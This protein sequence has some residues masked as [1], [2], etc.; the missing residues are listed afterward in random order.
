[1]SIKE[2]SPVGSVVGQLSCKDPDGGQSHSFII[3]VGIDTFEVNICLVVELC[4][5]R[6]FGNLSNFSSLI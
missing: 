2:N 6:W 3:E 5:K 1:M 4:P